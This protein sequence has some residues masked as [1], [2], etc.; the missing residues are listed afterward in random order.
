MGHRVC[1]PGLGSREQSP[2]V[3]NSGTHLSRGSRG[4]GSGEA[5]ALGDGCFCGEAALGSLEFDG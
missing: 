3:R 5:D 4:Q 1:P 2:P